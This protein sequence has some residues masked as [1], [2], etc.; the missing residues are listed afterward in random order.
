MIKKCIAVFLVLTFLNLVIMPDFVFA[1]TNDIIKEA[2]DEAFKQELIFFA[3]I[4]VF[5]VTA[6]IIKS[7]SYSQSS[8]LIEEPKERNQKNKVLFTTDDAPVTP[9]GQV[10]VL[11]W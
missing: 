3:I 2:G 9:S 11:K 6:L 10:V 8:S 7:K 1:T 4:G 5:L